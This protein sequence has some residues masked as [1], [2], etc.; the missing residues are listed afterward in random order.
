[1][2]FGDAVVPGELVFVEVD[3]SVP[4]AKRDKGES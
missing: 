2:G 3:P 4:E 1:M